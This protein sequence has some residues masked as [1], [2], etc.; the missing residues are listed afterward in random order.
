M[1]KKN[2]FEPIDRPKGIEEV[3]AI[4]AD[5]ARTIRSSAFTL[6][7]EAL[8][9]DLMEQS[10]ATDPHEHM[11]RQWLYDQMYALGSVTSKLGAYFTAAEAADE[12]IHQREL[13]NQEALARERQGLQ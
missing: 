9:R 3:K 1:T 13:E 8:V 11:K 12:A 5:A 2:T 10:A 6:A 7:Y 4:G